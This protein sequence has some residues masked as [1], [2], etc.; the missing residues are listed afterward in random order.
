[1]SEEIFLKVSKFYVL[2]ITSPV[3]ASPVTTLEMPLMLCVLFKFVLQS[4][5]N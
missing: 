5:W 2:M 3:F 1:M 4:T